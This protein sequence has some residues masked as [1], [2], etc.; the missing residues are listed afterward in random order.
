MLVSTL[1]ELE[2]EVGLVRQQCEGL[3]EAADAERR[4]RTGIAASL[5]DLEDAVVVAEAKRQEV[6]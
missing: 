1:G 4:A 5:S 6:C 2:E 3:C